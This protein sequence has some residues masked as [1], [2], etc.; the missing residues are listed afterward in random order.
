M[1]SRTDRAVG[2]A[3]LA[4]TVGLLLVVAAT[5]TIIVSPT[6]RERLREL[7]GWTPPSYQ[8][9]DASSLP[10][11]WRDAPGHTVLIFVTSNCDACRRS[12][13]FHQAI[14][15]AVGARPDLH[16]RIVLT[17]PGDDEAAYAAAIGVRAD[18]VT[19]INAR[20]TRLRRVPTIL[21]VDRQGIVVEKK[22]GV[23]PE[24]EQHALIEKL[25]KLLPL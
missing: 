4:A 15:G 6:A 13:P 12:L 25:R 23:L 11:A 2:R 8:V 21:I 18:Q 5:I 3:A 17:S 24:T 20:G 14:A 19:R 16:L 22:E 1:N 10:S 7:L 9:G